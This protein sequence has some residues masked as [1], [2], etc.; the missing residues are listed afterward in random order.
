MHFNKAVILKDSKSQSLAAIYHL[1][2]IDLLTKTPAEYKIHVR[3]EVASP[4]DLSATPFIG[5]NAR[6]L[7][8][9]DNVKKSESPGSGSTVRIKTL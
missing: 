1:Q 6:V 7:R 4:I 2:K 3:Q 9:Q 8:M 5:G